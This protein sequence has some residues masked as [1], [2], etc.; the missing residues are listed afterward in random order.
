MFAGLAIPWF[1][2]NKV[3]RAL[4]QVRS[5]P[6]SPAQP[7]PEVLLVSAR[8]ADRFGVRATLEPRGYSVLLADSV[9]E[10]IEIIGRQPD[11]I[12]IVV[13]DTDLP[14]SKRLV[15]AA[16]SQCRGAPVIALNGPREAGQVSGLVFNTA[17]D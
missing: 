9:E 10:G 14:Q 2:W 4:D 8:E 3:A 12:A 17:V 7:G 11:R 16:G 15:Q 1:D 6:P 5:H 13:I